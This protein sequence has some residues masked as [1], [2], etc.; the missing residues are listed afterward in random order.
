MI[1]SRILTQCIKLYKS[2]L[3]RE[4]NMMSLDNWSP[5]FLVRA[6]SVFS[7]SLTDISTFVDNVILKCID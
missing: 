5:E 6:K 3:K 2:P 7:T 1:I 4:K